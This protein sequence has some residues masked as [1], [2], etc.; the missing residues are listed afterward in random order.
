MRDNNASPL[1]GWPS[2]LI[3]NN[4]V[5]MS[6]ASPSQ[7]Q[8]Q[9]LADQ[10]MLGVLW[11]M[12]IY[13]L[14]VAYWFDGSILLAVSVGA[15]T[16]LALSVLTLLMPGSRVLR[17]VMGAALMV[18]AAL[19]IDVAHGVTELHF[20]I[21]V[22]LAFLVYYQDWLPIVVAALTAAVHHLVFFYL[23]QQSLS[24]FVLQDGTW[25]LVG[26]HAFYVVL[27]TLVLVVLAC[28][29]RKQTQLGERMIDTVSQ[30]T[31]ADG[32]L[33]LR[34][35]H[36]D[37][38]T[39]A[40]HI[41]DFLGRLQQMIG[42]LNGDSQTLKQVGERVQQSSQEVRG[43]AEHQLQELNVAGTGMDTMSLAIDDLARHVSEVADSVSGGS[44][45]VQAA[46]EVVSATRNGMQQ[47]AQ[48]IATSDAQ[49]Q[50]LAQQT[51]QIGEVTHVINTIAAQTNLLAL[52]A[53]I[54][55]ARAGEQGRGFAVVADEVRQLAQRTA[56]STGEIQQIV[57]TL[58]SNSQQA[59][60]LMHA[61]LD[62]AQGC[63]QRSEEAALLLQAVSQQM[64]ALEQMGSQI[65]GTV[66]EQVQL[67]GEV[68]EH[69]RTVQ[70]HSET[71]R[72]QADGLQADSEDLVNLAK[73]MAQRGQSFVL[74]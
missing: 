55:A 71:N 64:S 9:T 61:S 26:L 25:P 50:Q 45:Q 66:Q 72:Q 68:V 12:F 41:N 10:L 31:L 58:Q 22:L 24:F 32:R 8:Y 51:L 57:S 29:I 18:M 5:P 39:A 33:D 48:D 37:Q 15:G 20:G 52:N 74:R 56:A 63:L 17:C 73:Q 23:Q 38:T 16:A 3:K 70:A 60:T 67:T 42:L 49:I 36:P 4:V 11:S 30:I 65:A 54:E 43:G 1:W 46:N 28:H 62:S 2:K 19:Q 6:S 44:R 47:L 69:L 40:H 34:V 21:F 13:A 59:A 7:S 35:R 14:A 27:E 53:A